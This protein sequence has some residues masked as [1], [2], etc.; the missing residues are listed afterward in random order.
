MSHLSTYYAINLT[1]N[2]FISHR[3]NGAGIEGIQKPYG[4]SIYWK[5]LKALKC[6]IPN[7]E[8]SQSNVSPEGWNIY[9]VETG[10]A[11]EILLDLNVVFSAVSRPSYPTCQHLAGLARRVI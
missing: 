5:R 8:A 11:T 4:V 1:T 10:N 9:N 7:K 3:F 2:F 6:C